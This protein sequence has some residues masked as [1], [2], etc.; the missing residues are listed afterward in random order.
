MVCGRDEG[1]KWYVGG[2]R[3]VSGRGRGESGMW[4]G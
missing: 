4:E 2:V 1:S 3:V